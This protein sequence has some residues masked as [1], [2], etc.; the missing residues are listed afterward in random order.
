MT[1]DHVRMEDQRDGMIRP[2][3]QMIDGRFEVAAA[4]SCHLTQWI[5]IG[6]RSK[7]RTRD[8]IADLLH[9]ELIEACALGN[10]NPPLQFLTCRASRIIAAPL[11]HCVPAVPLTSLAGSQSSHL[12]RHISRARTVFSDNPAL[13]ALSK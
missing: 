6:S 8:R 3:N 2:Q 1:D 11:I 7:K 9:R 13:A 10:L 5:D 12:D 4:P